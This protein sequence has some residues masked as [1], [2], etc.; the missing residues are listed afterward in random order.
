MNERSM[1]DKTTQWWQRKLLEIDL[2]VNHTI[3]ITIMRPNVAQRA[4][5]LSLPHVAISNTERITNIKPMSSS[6][7][8]PWIKHKLVVSIY[9]KTETSLA[10][11]TLAMSVPTILMVSRCQ[12]SRFHTNTLNASCT[13]YWQHTTATH[14]D[15]RLKKTFWKRQA[16]CGLSSRCLWSCSFG[17]CSADGRKFGDQRRPIGQMARTRHY[18][19]I[20][21]WFS[22]SLECCYLLADASAFCVSRSSFYMPNY[23]LIF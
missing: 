6:Y 19:S 20:H 18:C 16:R 23:R 10:I 4:G 7:N 14:Y 21:E 13:S 2:S 9:S 3:N 11:S 8:T 5:Q 12:V 15:V 1:F 22:Q 17:W